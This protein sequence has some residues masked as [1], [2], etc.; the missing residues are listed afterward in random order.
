MLNYH[1]SSHHCL[2]PVSLVGGLEAHGLVLVL[3]R[4]RVRFSAVFSRWDSLALDVA[5]ARIREPG[6]SRCIKT[7]HVLMG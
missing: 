6:R 2:V 4:L 3:C 5:A 7:L 1:S